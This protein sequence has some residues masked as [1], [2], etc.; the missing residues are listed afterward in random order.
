MTTDLT[1]DAVLKDGN[2]AVI[3]GASSG[4]GRATAIYCASKGMNVYLADID[5]DELEAA[6]IAVQ[7]AATC[8]NQVRTSAFHTF[9]NASL[10]LM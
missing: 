1:A 5:G 9:Y 10:I 8:S 6:T 2:T 7:E 3:T 4:I